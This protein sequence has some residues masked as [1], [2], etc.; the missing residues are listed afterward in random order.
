MS[1]LNNYKVTIKEHHVDSLGHMN[2]ATYLALYEEARWEAI[3]SRG[4]GF[5]DI[6]KMKQGPV[7]LEVNLKFQR[8][9][10]LR[11]TITITLE[12]LGYKG[13]IAQ[14]KQ[15]MIK[16]DG[17]VASE[18]VFTFGLFDMKERK[19]IEPTPEWKRAIGMD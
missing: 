10:L 2:N 8:E 3:T 18:A 6:Q 15:Q 14:M 19:L 1:V 9:V 16:D 12:M 7:I 13:K 17:S 4:Y 5:R 11:E